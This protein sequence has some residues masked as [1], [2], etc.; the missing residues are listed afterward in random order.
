MSKEAS[1]CNHVWF[2]CHITPCVVL[3]T[4]RYRG[5]TCSVRLGVCC[6]DSHAHIV[7][8]TM[9]TTSSHA[10]LHVDILFGCKTRSGREERIYHMNGHPRV[11]EGLYAMIHNSSVLWL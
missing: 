7:T 10:P 1:E 8:H 3:A 2:H 5:G 11:A 9:P 4:E 6:L